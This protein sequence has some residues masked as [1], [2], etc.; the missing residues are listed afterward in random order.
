MQKLKTYEVTAVITMIK[1]LRPEHF[2]I[3]ATTK[4]DAIKQARKQMREGWDHTMGPVAYSAEQL[5]E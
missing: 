1:H 4:A 5:A 3:T 2:F